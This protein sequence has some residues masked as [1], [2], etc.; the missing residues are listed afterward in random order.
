MLE[1]TTGR[2]DRNIKKQAVQNRLKKNIML[3]RLQ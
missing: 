3:I 1:N 2:L